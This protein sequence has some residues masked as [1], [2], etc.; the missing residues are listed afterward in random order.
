MKPIQGNLQS[1]VDDHCSQMPSS[2]ANSRQYKGLQAMHSFVFKEL[3]FL[4]V[5]YN[6]ILQLSQLYFSY[7]QN[8]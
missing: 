5:F 3:Y 1:E 6:C 4:T 2:A 7:S 8:I